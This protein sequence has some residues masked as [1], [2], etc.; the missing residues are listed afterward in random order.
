MS[1]F[2]PSIFCHIP[3]YNASRL[4]IFCLFQFNNVIVIVFTGFYS[5]LFFSFFRVF[6]SIWMCK[7]YTTKYN[8]KRFG[9]ISFFSCVVC[10]FSLCHS[11]LF[12]LYLLLLLLLYALCDVVVVVLWHAMYNDHS[13]RS[14]NFYNKSIFILPKVISREPA[15]NNNVSLSHTLAFEV[16]SFSYWKKTKQSPHKIEKILFIKS[17]KRKI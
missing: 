2:F 12:F 4:C 16:V 3:T 6:Y 8:I 15:I 1:T 7:K 5:P 9:Y 13:F 10:L 11:V 17:K 14:L